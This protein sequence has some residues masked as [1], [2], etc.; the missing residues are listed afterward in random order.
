[1]VKRVI[2]IV[3]AVAVGGALFVALRTPALTTSSSRVD[4]STDTVARGRYLA[5]VGNCLSCHTSEGGAPY[6]G[7]VAFTTP[8][9]TIYSTNITS[10]PTAGI[11]SWSEAEFRR[12]MH[13]GIRKDGARL[14]PAF[15]YTSFTK[16]SDSDVAAMYAYFRTVPAS[17]A[18]P[19]ANSFVFTQ[20][21]TMAFWNELFFTPGRYQ[22]DSKQSDEWNRGAYLTEGLAH[23][24]A[25]HTPR[26]IFMAEIPERAL[27]GGT[28]WDHGT[29][30]KVRSW[31]AVNLSS[32]KSGLG[33]WRPADVKNYLLK[34]YSQ[35]AAV[36]GPM[37]EV[38][39]NST[40][41]LQ[42]SDAEA[43]TT[44]LTKMPPIGE[45]QGAAPSPASAKGG[46][47]LYVEHCEECHGASG[48]G[49]LFGGPPL[50]GSAIVRSIDP[51]SFLNI[52]LHGPQGPDDLE[53]GNWEDMQA[54]A[55]K[56]S[57]EEVAQLANYVRGAWSNRAPEVSPAESRQ[58]R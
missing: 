28:V 54:Y 17:S 11:G 45:Y 37:N 32:A 6:S 41:F 23:C 57:D 34:G 19:P 31:F 53:P 20:R 55:E 24:G 10:D 7:G 27:E 1:M 48:R 44:Y 42:E 25:C 52:V 58:Q 14:F 5:T 40:R 3:L 4:T 18:S 47:D 38:Y 51:S 33:A 15:P 26:N 36:F 12:A 35:R 39:S 22:V 43:I 49:S 30:G 13:Y 9:G 16:L 8:F 2:V 50:A 21:W 29:D 56:L 46:E